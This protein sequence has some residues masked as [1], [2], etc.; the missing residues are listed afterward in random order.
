VRKS[1][2]NNLND[3]SKTRPDIVVK[4]AKD[5]YGKNEYTDWIVKHACRTLL[6]KGDRDVL[7]IF[8]FSNVDAVSVSG[9]ALSAQTITLGE[10]IEFSF[11]IESSEAIKVRLEYGVDYM[12]SNGK[13]SRKIFQISE[14]AFKKNQKKAYTKTHSFADVSTRKHYPGA[15]SITLIVN[16]AEHGTLD[17]E[18][19]P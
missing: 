2:A 7:A 9:F 16:G 12:K 13:P 18:V 11:E 10:E 15:H 19:L 4:L 5:W 1:V 14:I 8:G 3:I 17:F 6:K